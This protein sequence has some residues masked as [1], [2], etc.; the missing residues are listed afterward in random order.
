MVGRLPFEDENR[1]VRA[2]LIGAGQFGE[3]L[4]KQS[5][6]I[7]GLVLAAVVDREPAR[8]VQAY[9]AAGWDEDEI[10]VCDEPI[11][12]QVAMESGRPVALA[13]ASLLQGLALDAVVEATGDPEAASLNALAAIEAGRHVVMASKEADSVV[14]PLLWRKAKAAGLVYTLVDGDQ[15]S[16]L[17]GLV[18][19]ARGLGF[20]IVAAGK[21]SEYDIVFD[22]D[23]GRAQRLNE[24]YEVHE[25]RHEWDLDRD[26]VRAALDRRHR[27]LLRAPRSTPPD[28]CEMTLVANHTGLLPDRPDLH[29]PIARTPELPDIFRPAR[30]GGLLAHEGSLDIFN[31]LRRPDE[32]SFAGGVFVVVRM[33]DRATGELLEEKGHPVDSSGRFLLW[34]N[35]VHL[36]GLEAPA[37][38][39]AA[40]RLGRGTSGSEVRAVI[41]LLPRAQE[42]LPA[43]TVLKLGRRHAIAGTS[44]EM[45]SARA[46][47]GAEAPL[48]Y[49]MAAGRRLVRDVRMGQIITLGDIEAPADSL[50]WR[51]RAE[52]DTALAEG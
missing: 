34:H 28:L 30:V 36:L 10:A 9:V 41:D 51:L 33:P 13:D 50:F 26:S 17:I 3:T 15:P 49:Y 24:T 40:A 19:R 29:A 6:R 31:C 37:S 11:A 47:T 14:G 45:H 20:D 8:A 5:R 7:Q 52:Q 38:I 22:P 43:G 46:V 4:I 48:P 23:T 18:A 21:A 2:A 35:P 25:L 42:N 16:L 12:A 32:A 44:A 39:L 1:R 27:Y